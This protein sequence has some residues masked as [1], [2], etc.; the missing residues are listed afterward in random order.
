MFGTYPQLWTVEAR[1]SASLRALGNKY[2]LGNK[3]ALGHAYS[4][5]KETLLKITSKTR[6]QKRSDATREKM[7]QAALR[8]VKE[9]RHNFH[10]PNRDLVSV[11]KRNDGTYLEWSRAIKR[12]DGRRCKLK[13]D[14]C[15]K[16]VVAHHIKGW[17]SYPEL[18]YELSNGITL[19]TGHH[20]RTREREKELEP[21]L[22]TMVDAIMR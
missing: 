22:S 17:A 12:R 20:P 13:D 19:C 11:G 2:S 4:P 8:R 14:T 7:R 3:N 5:T 18:R 10:N 1:K 6:G 9:G 15:S 21:T 16:K